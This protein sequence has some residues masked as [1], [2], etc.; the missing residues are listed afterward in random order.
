[1]GYHGNIVDLWWAQHIPKEPGSAAV[2]SWATCGIY[3]MLFLRFLPIRERLVQEHE[4]TGE[5][6]VDLGSDQTSLHNPFNGGYYPVQL[7]FGQAN[8]L[9]TTDPHRFK[10]VVQDRQV[11]LMHNSLL[12][13]FSSN[14][15][16]HRGELKTWFSCRSQPSKTCQGH[17][18]ACRC[19]DVLLGLRQRISPGGPESWL[20]IWHYSTLSI[21]LSQFNPHQTLKELFVMFLKV[22]R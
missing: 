5:L 20:V 21:W 1:M 15:W 2:K 11:A 17:Q 9:M 8:Q 7:S 4:R 6:L 3:C 12:K 22:Q 18:Q 13:C 19:W 10:T 14:I 16:I